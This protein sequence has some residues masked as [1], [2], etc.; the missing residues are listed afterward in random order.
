MATTE[1]LAL[2]Y[3][4]ECPDLKPSMGWVQFVCR[5]TLNVS[6]GRETHPVNLFFTAERNDN[7]ERATALYFVLGNFFYIALSC[8]CR[9]IMHGAVSFARPR[10]GA[11]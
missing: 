10:P 5:A 4:C 7:F 9:V 3:H 1:L 8:V 2:N 6:C 11:T